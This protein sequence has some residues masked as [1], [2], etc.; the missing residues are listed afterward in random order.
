MYGYTPYMNQ[1]QY[2]IQPQMQTMGMSGRFV[3]DFN[4]VGA[5]DVP[6]DGKYATFIKNDL[7]E[8][9]MRKWNANGIIESL[10]Y[11]PFNV[12]IATQTTNVSTN[13]QKFDIGAFNE[14]L[15]GIENAIAMLSEKIDKT[16]KPIRS[17]KEVSDERTDG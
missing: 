17:K 6:M 1:Q 16:N 2:G 5:N 15:E 12:P 8:I 9:Q 7:S 13:N 11:K 4:E 14:R 3:N 10:S